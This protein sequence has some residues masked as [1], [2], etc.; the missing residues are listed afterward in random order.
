MPSHP[1]E[2]RLAALRA[3]LGAQRV[4]ALV[5]AAAAV[6]T[7]NLPGDEA[8]IFGFLQRILLHLRNQD[9]GQGM[10]FPKTDAEYRRFYDY[11]DGEGRI[12]AIAPGDGPEQMRIDP[13]WVRPMP[14]MPAGE[15]YF[16]VAPGAGG[17]IVAAFLEAY[18]AM[19]ARGPVAG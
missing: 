13:A 18:A 7:A 19:L 1:L 6:G 12:V 5:E 4:D 10:L 14:G 11:F 9:R 3:R 8:P 15:P 2:D 16:E 17:E